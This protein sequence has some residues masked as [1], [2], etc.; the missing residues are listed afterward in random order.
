MKVARQQ[1]E[2]L[3]TRRP[4]SMGRGGLVE[5]PL[6][7][8]LNATP[9][10]LSSSTWTSKVATEAGAAGPVGL[11]KVITGLLLPEGTGGK[12]RSPQRT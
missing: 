3:D 5:A 2:S 12:E 1:A 7:V 8:P 9:S 11:E 4:S 10:S 6:H